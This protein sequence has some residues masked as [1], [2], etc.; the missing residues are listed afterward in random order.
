MTSANVSADSFALPMVEG[1]RFI[2]FSHST[3]AFSM[4]GTRSSGL[5]LFSMYCLEHWLMSDM[6][7]STKFAQCRK[8]GCLAY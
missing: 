7:S 1:S 6:M 4:A 3:Q 5:H 2:Q 8:R